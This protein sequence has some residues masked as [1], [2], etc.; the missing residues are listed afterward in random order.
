MTAIYCQRIDEVYVMRITQATKSRYIIPVK[1]GSKYENFLVM[2]WHANVEN[3]LIICWISESQ[4]DFVRHQGNNVRATER[5][6]LTRPQTYKNIGVKHC[7]GDIDEALSGADVTESMDPTSDSMVEG[8]K[9]LA[10]AYHNTPSKI[11][12]DLNL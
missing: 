11:T 7:R 9:I 2:F 10:S 4:I 5:R 8:H 1:L 3:D 6:E 12:R